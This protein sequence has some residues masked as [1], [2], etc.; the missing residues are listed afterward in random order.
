[1][2]ILST[3]RFCRDYSRLAIRVFDPP[4]AF[5]N[6]TQTLDLR[7]IVPT[8]LPEAAPSGPRQSEMTGGR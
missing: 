3:S 2:S 8:F 4:H 1:M 7:Q 6:K 5:V